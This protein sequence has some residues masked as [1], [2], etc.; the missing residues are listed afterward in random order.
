MTYSQAQLVN[1]AG[2]AGCSQRTVRR[3]AAAPYDVHYGTFVRLAAACMRVGYPIPNH[4]VQCTLQDGRTGLGVSCI[5]GADR[6]SAEPCRTLRRAGQLF[7]IKD[8]GEKNV[9]ETNA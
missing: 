3:F 1:L 2:W 6:L 9:E 8:L 5:I 4:P 7:V